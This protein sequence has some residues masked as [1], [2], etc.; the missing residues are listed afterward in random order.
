LRERADAERKDKNYKNKYS[1]HKISFIFLFLY[2]RKS[3][4]EAIKK[5]FF[6]SAFLYRFEYKPDQV[7]RKSSE[8]R[9]FHRQKNN[10]I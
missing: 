3:G 10:S 2:W 9:G 4:V 6:S 1:I 5:A 7:R 8:D